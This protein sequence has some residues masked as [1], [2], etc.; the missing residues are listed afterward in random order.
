MIASQR[1]YMLGQEAGGY[2]GT[3]FTR[4]NST[5]TS[6]TD[7]RDKK[8]GVGNVWSPGAFALPRKVCLIFFEKSDL[9]QLV[10][11]N[12]NLNPIHLLLDSG[13]DI[14]I[15]SKQVLNTFRTYH[16]CFSYQ[17][18]C[19]CLDNFNPLFS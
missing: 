2:G 17:D 1:L 5:V 10:G 14:F 11:A 18:E 16:G 12:D 9:N 8:I 7:I 19:F 3:I 4:V 13:I 15:D 6:L